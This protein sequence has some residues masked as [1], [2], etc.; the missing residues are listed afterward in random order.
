LQT[1][2]EISRVLEKGNS[3]LIDETEALSHEVGKMI[4]GILER[5]KD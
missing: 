5:I 1:Q 4:Y 3:K 2:L